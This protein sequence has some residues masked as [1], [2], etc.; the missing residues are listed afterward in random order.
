[1][2]ENNNA[3][4]TFGIN[5]PAISQ[6]KKKMKTMEG[7]QETATYK[8]VALKTLVF[9]ALCVAGVALFF[10]LHDILLKAVPIGQQVKLTLFEGVVDLTTCKT[11]I[12]LYVVAFIGTIILPFVICFAQKAVPVL[13]SIV[14][15]CEGYF[16]GILIRG[17]GQDYRWIPFLALILTF[18]IVGAM[19]LLY[20]TR[21]IKVTGKFRRI[22]FSIVL[23]TLFASIVL[24]ILSI[25]PGI[26]SLVYGIVQFQRSPI[27]GIIGGIAYL[28][29]AAIFLAF[30]FN[31][32]ENCVKER[33][34]KSFEWLV[35]FGLAYT[36]IYI[37]F[38]VLNI[39]IRIV[40]MTKE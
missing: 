23:A 1:M 32:I 5:N 33:M 30:D 22:F 27:F 10:V 8:G 26:R 2:A 40:A 37:Y 28:I 17:L 12:V 11:E 29:F 31:D 36:I 38:E 35:S 16:M 18:A 39:I 6:V 3:K 13:G 21:I 25:I 15:V 9:L 4:R 34:P 19:L 24:A 14:A 7:V 20:S